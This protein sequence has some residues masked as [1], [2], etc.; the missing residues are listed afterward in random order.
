MIFLIFTS[1]I[2]DVLVPFSPWV[3]HVSAKLDI[4]LNSRILRTPFYKQDY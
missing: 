3:L 2:G 1:A 4:E